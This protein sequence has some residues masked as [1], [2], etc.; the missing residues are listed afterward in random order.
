MMNVL[1]SVFAHFA[2]YFQSNR[3]SFVIISAAIPL[4]ASSISPKEKS[5][6]SLTRLNKIVSIEVLKYEIKSIYHPHITC[7]CSAQI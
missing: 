2:S 6:L 4:H 1:N 7:S 5:T 3:Q